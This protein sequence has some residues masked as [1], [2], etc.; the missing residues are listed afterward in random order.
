MSTAQEILDELKPLGRDSYKRTMMKN[1]GV[2]EPYFGVAIGELKKIQ[3]RIKVDYQLALDLYATGNYDAMYL[4]GLITDDARM[5]R[6]DLQRWAEGAYAGSLSGATVPGV[7]AGSPF[8]AEMAGKWL[9]SA[10]PL[11]AATGW[12]T[13]SAI[14]SVTPDSELDLPALRRLL[15]R[16]E[17]SIHQAPDAVRYEMNMFVIAVGSYVVPLSKT[18]LEVGERIGPVTAD[19]GP[20]HC[21]VFSAPDHIR[22]VEGLGKIGRKRKSAKC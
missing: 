16:V 5:T 3:K 22:K 4:A 7:A 8:G 15:E 11:V 14:V 6:L 12:A 18:A 1:Y 19:L 2:K 20:N 13:W 10:E 21:Q 17:K 9:D